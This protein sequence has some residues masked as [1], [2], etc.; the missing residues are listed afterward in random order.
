M[1]DHDNEQC[2]TGADDAAELA[3]RLTG[4]RRRRQTLFDWMHPQRLA[5]FPFAAPARGCGSTHAAALADAFLDDAGWPMPPWHAF[6]VPGA[7]LLRLPVRECL[8]AFRLRALLEHTDDVRS[9]IDRPRRTLLCDWVGVHGARVLLTRPRDLDSGVP[10][11]APRAAPPGPA[12]ADAL[13]WRGLR[14]FE[15]E[16]GWPPGGPLALAQFALPEEQA[17]DAN[18]A[19]DDAHAVDGETAGLSIVSQLSDLFPEHL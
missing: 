5:G 18:A 19:L 10:A 17:D 8:A 4:Y 3:A 14:L 16:C 12:S 6:D 7:A 2:G 1:S 11:G 9:W 15:R 13:A